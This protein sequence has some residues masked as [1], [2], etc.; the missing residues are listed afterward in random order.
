MLPVIG[1]VVCLATLGYVWSDRPGA[2]GGDT[3]AVTRG[4]SV[5]D[6]ASAPLD[7]FSTAMTLPSPI[8]PLVSGSGADS[9][10]APEPTAV[11]EVVGTTEAGLAVGRAGPVPFPARVA[12]ALGERV[13]LYSAYGEAEPAQWLD[14]PTWEGLDVVFLVQEERDDWLRVQ[15]SMRPNQ[16]TVWV[17]ASDVEMRTVVHQIVVDVTNLRL[18]LYEDHRPVFEAPV[19]P[20]KGST[21]TPIGN[22]FV[23]GIVALRDT[24]G[25]YGSHQISVA[26]FSEVYTSFGGGIGQI[27]LHGTN[28]PTLL[29]TPVSNGCVRMSNDDIAHLASLVPT[30]TPVQIVA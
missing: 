28:Q 25:P 24:T 22:F 29:G 19:A 10:A 1:L 11:D 30:G 5:D 12:D 9:A 16:A 4:A 7:R 26:G 23:D 13:P 27:A 14:N 17:K 15:V 6:L 8:A 3:V 20:G 18:V 21:P 2:G